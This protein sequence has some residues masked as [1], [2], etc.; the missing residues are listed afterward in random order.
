MIA[1]GL[2]TDTDHDSDD[3]MQVEEGVV[4][5]EPEIKSLKLRRLQQGQDPPAAVGELEDDLGD[6]VWT[7]T[8]SVESG[9]DGVERTV[10]HGLVA[11]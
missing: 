10:F 2:R 11:T 6:I 7:W 9:L 1:R 5:R 3:G 4:S 8:E